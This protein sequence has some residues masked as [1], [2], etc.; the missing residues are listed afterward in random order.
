MRLPHAFAALLALTLPAA[1]QR[2]ISP[3]F[4][5]DRRIRFRC[6]RRGSLQ[7]ERTARSTHD[8]TQR[9]SPSAMQLRTFSA[10]PL[11][12]IAAASASSESTPAPVVDHLFP[13]SAGVLEIQAQS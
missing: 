7:G 10:L 8:H 5:R 12:A 4:R 9:T 11:S 2:A 13:S 3:G 1:A 6:E